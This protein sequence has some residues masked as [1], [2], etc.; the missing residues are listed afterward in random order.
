MCSDSST[1]AGGEGS[2]GVSAGPHRAEP[3]RRRP[4]KEERRRQLVS[5][6]AEQVARFRVNVIG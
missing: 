5:T 1:P 3:D 6:D 4:G 2:S